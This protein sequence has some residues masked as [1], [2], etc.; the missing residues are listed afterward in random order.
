MTH[1]MF[2]RGC[3]FSCYFCAAPQKTVQ[4]RSG[5]NVRD[6]LILLRKEYNIEGF[7]VVDDNSIINKRRVSNICEAISD[8]GLKWT[9]LSRVD[10]VDKNTLEKM[11]NAGCIEIAFGVESGSEKI[12]GSMNKKISKQ[13]IKTAI[14]MADSVGIAVKI[15]LIHG[16]PGENL[17]TTL[18]T[19]SLL[20]EIKPMIHRVSL[21]R[22]VPLPGSYVYRNR[23]KF[24]LNINDEESEYSS[25]DW[26]KYHIHHNHY[27]WWGMVDDFEIMN[28][29]YQKLDTFVK[30]NWLSRHTL[31]Y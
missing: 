25:I 29:A 2:S 13:Q 5:K 21:F 14:R 16:F 31:G 17:D 23:N 30:E 27:H 24:R 7:S 6:E 9:T 15:F 19:L 26:G 12:L 1:V 8:L 10:T 20:E 18:E 11:R 3:P 28:T 4:F 22:F